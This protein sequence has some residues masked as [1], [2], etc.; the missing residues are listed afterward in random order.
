MLIDDL[1]ELQKWYK[2]EFEHGNR[3]KASKI[4]RVFEKHYE[5]SSMDTQRMVAK[6]EF[7]RELLKRYLYRKDD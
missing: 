5:N 7:D 2:E 6:L 4:F 1:D 3:I